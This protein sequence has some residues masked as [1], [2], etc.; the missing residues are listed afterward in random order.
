MALN[1]SIEDFRIDISKEQSFKYLQAKQYDNN[2]RKKRLIITDNNIPLMLS[3]KE[4]VTLSLSLNGDNYSNT[5]CQFGEDGYPY[6]VFTDSMLSKEGDV[7]CE[8]RIYD[9]DGISVVTTFNFVM[10]VQRSL[11]DEDRI[12]ESSEFNVLNDLI[13]QANRIPELEKEFDETVEEIHQMQTEI[14][15]WQKTAEESENT[16]IQN[17][18]ERIDAENKRAEAETQRNNAET[19]RKEAET[20]RNNTENTRIKNENTRQSNEETRQSNE[21]TR[22]EQEQER[23]ENTSI[24]IENVNAAIENLNFE[25]RDC[26]G[27]IA[28][29]QEGDYNNDYNG[30]GATVIDIG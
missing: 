18:T 27:G 30:G 1:I 20:I 4:L 13:L 21:Q 28:T 15:E 24:A 19:E 29:S 16:R 12:V 8:I 14:E 26:D 11:L 7:D 5:T 17:E 23:Q 22:I 10:T 6:I 3:G 2:S 25:L 9:S